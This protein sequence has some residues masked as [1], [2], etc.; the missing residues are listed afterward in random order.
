[1]MDTD[2]YNLYY[3]KYRR[4]PG[5]V[6]EDPG[7]R[8]NRYELKGLEDKTKYDV[9]LTGVN[10]LGEGPESVHYTGVTAALDPPVTPVTSGSMWRC[11]GEPVTAHIES[12][13]YGYDVS[14]G[15]YD[16]VDGNYETSWARIDWVQVRPIMI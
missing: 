3:R 1:M 10:P 11:Q 4:L 5:S 13:R 2:S 12:V 14:K 8:E 15:E 7:Y 6:H 16:I 9:Y